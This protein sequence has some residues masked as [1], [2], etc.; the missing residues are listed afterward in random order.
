MFNWNRNNKMSKG[1]RSNGHMSFYMCCFV[2]H[3]PGHVL[4]GINRSI[5]G[6]NVKG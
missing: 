6:D 2:H 5:F 4:D 1:N 3:F